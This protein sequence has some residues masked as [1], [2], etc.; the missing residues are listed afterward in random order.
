MSSPVAGAPPELDDPEA[1]V[2]CPVC[3]GEYHACPACFGDGVMTARQAAGL[4]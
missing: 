3:Q 4:G 2:A 1:I